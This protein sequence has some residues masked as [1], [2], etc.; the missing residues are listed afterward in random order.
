MSL[1]TF[2]VSVSLDGF[3]AGP[4][5]RLE[6]PLGDGGEDL[7]RWL[8]ELEVWRRMAG[9]AGGVTNAST[10]VVEEATANVGA[11]VMGRNMFG[12]YPGGWSGDPPWR[13][14]WGDD[15]PYHTPVFV[16]T[17][18]AREPLEM[19]GGTTFHFVTE[20]AEAAMERAKE[21]AADRDVSIAGGADV[22]RQ[23][24][25]A[26]L[27]DGF[28]LHIAPVVLGA[29]ERP[30]EDVGD[31]RLEQTRAIEAPGVTHVR[32]RVIR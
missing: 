22:I 9:Q 7:H 24:L 1:V 11:Y 13:G 28:E 25:R 17:H 23:Y 18:H 4:N 2:Q 10:Q 16:L 27:V 5:Q 26:G 14:W 31:L 12:G 3:M 8:V 30:L 19:G 15:P 6:V 20:G 29:G 21:A 32:Y